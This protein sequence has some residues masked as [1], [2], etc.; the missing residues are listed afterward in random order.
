[1]KNISQQFSTIF[2]LNLDK[3]SVSVITSDV[4]FGKEN[5]NHY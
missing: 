3:V 2:A 4:D 1:M 5:T